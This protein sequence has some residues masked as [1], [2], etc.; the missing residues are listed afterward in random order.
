LDQIL[1]GVGFSHKTCLL[2]QVMTLNRLIELSSELAMSEWVGRSALGDILK[3]DF[4]ELNKDR[5]YRNMGRLYG[6]RSPIEAALSA[7]EKSFSQGEQLDLRS[8]FN[9]FRRLVPL[10]SKSQARLLA[11]F[12]T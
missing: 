8:D 1:A 2:T 3:Q 7:K 12:P 9:L 4:A 11:R 5:L 10:Q 6:K